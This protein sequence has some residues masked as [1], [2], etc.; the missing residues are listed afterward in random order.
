[1]MRVFTGKVRETDL[2]FSTAIFKNEMFGE[3]WL[4]ETGLDGD[5]QGS[6]GIHGGSERGLAAISVH[7]LCLVA[8]AFSEKEG[9][10]Q[11]CLVWRESVRFEM[12]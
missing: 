10:F 5:E 2:G 8:I 6:P 12:A 3:L 11:A 7:S 9:D 1:M 4:G